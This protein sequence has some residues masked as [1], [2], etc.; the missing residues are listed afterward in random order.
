M[1]FSTDYCDLNAIRKPGL[2][3]PGLRS[4]QI[5]VYASATSFDNFGS[6][7]RDRPVRDT[8]DWSSDSA[9]RIGSDRKFCARSRGARTDIDYANTNVEIPG[10]A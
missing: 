8:F 4:P 3:S 1:A 9:V 7:S 10:S 6:R 2:L 5:N